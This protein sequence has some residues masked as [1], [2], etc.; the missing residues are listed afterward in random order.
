MLKIIMV[1]AVVLLAA[2]GGIALVLNHY[3]GWKGLLAF[4]VLLIL[5]VLGGKFVIGRLFKRFVLGLVGMKARA[6][7]GASMTVHSI[8][9]IPKPAEP[10]AEPEVDSE[11]DAE[12]AEDEAGDDEPEEKKEPRVYYEIDVTITPRERGGEAVWEQSELML[13]SG[14]IK[15]LED[16]ENQEVGTTEECLLWNGSVFVNDD[17]GK[18]PGPQRVKLTMAVKPGT[19][20]AWLH[21][22][23]EKIGRLELPDWRPVPSPQPGGDLRHP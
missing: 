17:V 6:L 2:A 14:P 1:V 7:R 8:V 20:E 11:D 19:R 3:F 15:S 9:P 5:L 12:D 16:L 23:H 10:E 21:Y 4:P 22:Y 18:Q 13:T